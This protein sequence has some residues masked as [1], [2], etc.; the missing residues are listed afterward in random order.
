MASSFLR[1]VT[2]SA[3]LIAD[4]DPRRRRTVGRIL[5]DAG[6]T[7]HE[8]ATAADALLQAERW[9]PVVAVVDRGLR[10]PG[11]DGVVAA[12]RTNPVTRD[13]AVLVLT[14]R[15]RPEEAATALAEGADDFVTT[16]LDT[17]ELRVRVAALTSRPTSSPGARG[18]G[19]RIELF[20]PL[21]VYVDRRAVIDERFARRKVKA[22]LVYL[23]LRRE[24]CLSREEL[25]DALWPESDPQL[26]RGRLKQTVLMLR[27]IVEPPRSPGA[28]WRYIQKKGGTYC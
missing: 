8:A 12:M 15:D 25:V 28:D 23:W 16:P 11:G 24:D 4:N 14:P 1:P 10:G 19:F 5:T 22:L 27:S 18:P 6:F 20:G 21:L 7:V 3:V 26:A 17:D 9:R 13:L 2:D